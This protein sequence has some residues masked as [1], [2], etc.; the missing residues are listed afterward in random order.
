MANYRGGGQRKDKHWDSLAGAIIL[1]TGNSTFAASGSLNLDEAWT[2]IRMLGEYTIAP[3]SAPAALDCAAIAVG[4]GV[5]STDAVA[6]GA[7]AL[8]DPGQEPSFPW[9]YWADHSLQFATTTADPSGVAG[10][11]RHSFDVRS[12]RKL[13][14]REALLMVGEYIN[15]VGNPP[16]TFHSGGTRILVAT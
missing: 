13:K 1:S 4:I 12:M 7:S 16:L 8:P 5:F 6:V 10:T 15:V 9:L 11:V 3:T 2:V 14:P